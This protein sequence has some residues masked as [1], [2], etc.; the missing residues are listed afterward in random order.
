VCA[1]RRQQSPCVSV[2]LAERPVWEIE[3]RATGLHPSEFMAITIAIVEDDAL[4]RENLSRLIDEAPGFRCAALYANAEQALQ[5]I[6]REPPDVVLMD[7]NLPR[8]SGI[9]CVRRLKQLVPRLRIMVL[10]VYEDS[11]KV[12]AALEAGAG[13]YLLKR[14]PPDK[15]LEAI[16]DIHEGG[17]PMSSYI[18]RKVVQSF[19]K[20][21]ADVPEVN[22]L[23]PREQEI[24]HLMASAY[25]NKEIATQLRISP[26]TVRV[27]LRH[28]Y[29][30]LHV[31]SR[32][33]AVV[34]LFHKE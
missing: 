32:S 6:P 4:I 31:N 5:Q 9:E 26:E 10:T 21:S 23:S 18:A 27:H 33:Q 34:K 3:P 13:G 14:T 24:L 20:S 2:R 8:V 1:G 30:K 22:Q 19:Q 28:I 16:R 15:L 12:F 7:L 29:E 25:H 17:A 11:D